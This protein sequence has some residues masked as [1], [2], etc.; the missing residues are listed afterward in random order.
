MEA[1]FRTGA[2]RMEKNVSAQFLKKSLDAI[3][4]GQ[5]PKRLAARGSHS[6]PVAIVAD[7]TPRYR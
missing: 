4:M 1:M 6:Q 5:R 3:T 7:A 2:G